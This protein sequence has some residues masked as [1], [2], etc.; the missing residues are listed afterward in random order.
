M[1]INTTVTVPAYF[2]PTGFVP[3]R[4][5][6]GSIVFHEG[7]WCVTS[8]Y[9]SGSPLRCK[10]LGAAE[11]VERWTLGAGLQLAIRATR[12]SINHPRS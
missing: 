5:E 11:G 6:D 2:A 9:E 12:L 3:V 7:P 10:Y 4:D 8:G 1:P